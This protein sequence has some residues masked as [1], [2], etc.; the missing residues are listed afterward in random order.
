MEN[1]RSRAAWFFL[2]LLA[3]AERPPALY[4]T[5][6]RSDVK[7][8]TRCTS[9]ARKVMIKVKV[10]SERG[11]AD[12]GATCGSSAKDIHLFDKNYIYAY[13]H[14]QFSVPFHYAN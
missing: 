5:R 12:G 6:R 2:L 1:K 7:T 9:C 10:L 13:N 4:V 11:S 3:V 8:Q 14:A